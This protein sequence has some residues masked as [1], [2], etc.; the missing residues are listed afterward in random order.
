MAEAR[1]RLLRGLLRLPRMR[2]SRCSWAAMEDEACSSP[3]SSGWLAGLRFDN[4]A[5]RALPLDP[6][7][8]PAGPRP[9]P[10]ACFARAQPSPVRGPRLVALSLPALSLLGL[11]EPRGAA[12]E[13]EAALC[14]SGNRLPPGAEPAAHCYC[15][16]QFGSF[17]GQLG[18]GAALYLG[19]VVNARGERWEMQLKGAGPTPFS[20]YEAG[21]HARTPFSRALLPPPP[22]PGVD[23]FACRLPTQQG[24]IWPLFTF[25][26]DLRKKG[27]KNVRYAGWRT[28]HTVCLKQIEIFCRASLWGL[29][30]I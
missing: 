29:R 7:Q 20:R 23:L 15:G 12:E 8:E 16:H 14:L 30:T 11:R 28:G 22:G 10:G 3:A 1:R 9:V 19:E 26:Q 24:L 4:L 6:G 25:Q 13:A 5:L 17:A 21:A 2:P 27:K 18:D